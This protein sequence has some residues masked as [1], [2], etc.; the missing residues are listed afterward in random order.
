ML[1]SYVTLDMVEEI[2]RYYRENFVTPFLDTII[3]RVGV[4]SPSEA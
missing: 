3:T 4:G 1:K 2:Q